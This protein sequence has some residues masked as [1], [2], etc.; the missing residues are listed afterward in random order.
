MDFSQVERR[1][2]HRKQ[3]LLQIFLP[4]GAG[5]LLVLAGAVF[6]VLGA[7]DGGGETA[8]WAQ[9]S[10]VWL[11]LPILV[12][13]VLYGMMLVIAIYGLQR[14]YTSFPKWFRTIDNIV[15]IL[16]Y[17][18]RRLANEAVEPVLKFNMFTSGLGVLR[19]PRKALKRQYD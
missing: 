6:A 13:G 1:K 9:I 11:I 3:T 10:A 16:Y 15:I 14:L 17:W 7:W 5:V 4:L 8:R 12:V 2:N 19:H 18:L